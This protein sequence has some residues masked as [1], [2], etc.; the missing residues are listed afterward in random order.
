MLLSNAGSI[1]IIVGSELLSALDYSL[2]CEGSK[3][4]R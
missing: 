2:R 4:V 1:T 3:C